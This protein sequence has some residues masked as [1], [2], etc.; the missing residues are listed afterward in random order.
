MISIN[1]AGCSNGLSETR[2]SS[3]GDL[4]PSLSRNELRAARLRHFVEPATA[5]TSAVEVFCSSCFL[6]VHFFFVMRLAFSALRP[7][8]MTWRLMRLA[9]LAFL[10][11]PDW[12]KLWGG[13]RSRSRWLGQWTRAMLDLL[14]GSKPLVRIIWSTRSM[15][16]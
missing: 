5:S 2:Q 3:G 4:T 12:S 11:L 6:P 9:L 15:R 1:S 7:C 10:T 13:I 8:L 16:R 14:S